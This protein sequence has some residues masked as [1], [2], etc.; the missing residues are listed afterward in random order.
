MSMTSSPT[1]A[2]RLSRAT[3]RRLI[4]CAAACVLALPAEA[5][6][7]AAMRAP[8]GTEGARDWAASL[9]V[10]DLQDAS[11][12]IQDY[13]YYYRRAIMAALEPDDRAATWRHY[14]QNYASTHSLDPASR[15]VINRAVAAMTPEVFDDG[16]PAEQ[17]A[18]LSTVFDIGVGL[19]GRRTAVDLFMRLGPDDGGAESLAAL[20]VA[21]R[22]S[23]RLRGWLSV[24]AENA[25]CDCTTAFGGSCDVA[26]L[27]GAEVCSAAAS[28][29]PDVS[30]PMSGVA[31]SFPANGLCTNMSAAKP[32]AQAGFPA[33]QSQSR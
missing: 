14:L 10:T 29:E 11:Q 15:L 28:C 6:L 13:P 21:E 9:S 24:N 22:M 25:D 3:R 30:W 32:L 23:A 31:W 19:F 26:G 1:P 27:T 2:A 8:N 12:R 7:L 4:V 16:A 17:L 5:A 18:E 33:V 20:P